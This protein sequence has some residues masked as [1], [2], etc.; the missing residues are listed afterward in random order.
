MFVT[1]L[2]DVEDMYDIKHAKVRVEPDIEDL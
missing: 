2:S 1:S